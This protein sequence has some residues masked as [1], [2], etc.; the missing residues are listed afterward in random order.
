MAGERMQRDSEEGGSDAAV[1]D[2]VGWEDCSLSVR[3]R[4][5]FF[6]HLFAFSF[7]L[8]LAEHSRSQLSALLCHGLLQIIVI[9]KE[10][11]HFSWLW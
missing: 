4:P 2:E 7:C 1:S 6:A 11:C 8:S 3:Q 5:A 9:I 10:K